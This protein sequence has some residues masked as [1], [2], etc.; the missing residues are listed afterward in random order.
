M[1]GFEVFVV[2]GPLIII[3]GIYILIQKKVVIG[4]RGIPIVADGVIAR[5]MGLASIIGGAALFFAGGLQWLR[6]VPESLISILVIIGLGL[7]GLINFV[8][9]ILLSLVAMRKARN[10]E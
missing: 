6:I 3:Y 7:I 9:V 4:I 1:N 5:S 8:G 10:R 2:G